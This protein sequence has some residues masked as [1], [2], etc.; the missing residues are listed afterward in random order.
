M[1]N[2]TKSILCTRTTTHHVQS[3]HE[4]TKKTQ[5][6]KRCSRAVPHNPFLSI[7]IVTHIAVMQYNCLSDLIANDIVLKLY[8]NNNINFTK[9]DLA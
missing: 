3:P 6:Y 8:C 4:Q 5:E 9:Y 1:A 2:N 7:P